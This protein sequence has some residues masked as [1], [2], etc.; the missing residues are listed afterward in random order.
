MN[1]ESARAEFREVTPN[2]KVPLI[3]LSLGMHTNNTA[4]IM[5]ILHRNPQ[6]PTEWSVTGVERPAMG[7]HFEDCM[8]AIR[9]EVDKFVDEGLK[10]ERVL[11]MDATFNMQKND[12]ASLPPEVKAVQV[13]LGWTYPGD[14]DFDTSIICLD[15]N[16]Q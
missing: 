13:A 15:K 11:T 7:K 14:C 8:P 6:Q 12:S 2:G 5:C 3:N 16:R 10:C 9:E 4:M 1:V